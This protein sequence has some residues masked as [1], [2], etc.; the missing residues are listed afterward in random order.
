MN[1][2]LLICGAAALGAAAAWL[3][4]ATRRRTPL[5]KPI[6]LGT[7]LA[8]LVRALSPAQATETVFALLRDQYHCNRV[9]FLAKH[10]RFLQVE[11][12]FGL[13]DSIRQ[14][15]RLQY[16]PS[17]VQACISSFEP[18]DISHIREQAPENVWRSIQSCRLSHCLPV[19]WGD[20]VY[21]IM[22][23]G[24]PESA[25]GEMHKLGAVAQALAAVYHLQWS[26]MSAGKTSG[27]AQTIS[28][29][30]DMARPARQ[31]LKLV[32]HRNPE[33]VVR[34]L[35]SAAQSEIGLE[36]FV[37]MYEPR[38]KGDELQLVAGGVDR[39]V[40]IPGQDHF[41]GL[42][43]LLSSEKA[44]PIF[45]ASAGSGPAADLGKALLEG[46]ISHALLF[47]L[48]DDRRGVFAWGD[49]KPAELITRRLSVFRAAAEDLLEN[50]ESFEKIE[51]LSQTDALTGLYNHRYFH[52]RLT[53]EVNRARR[54]KRSLG[55]VMIDLDQLKAIN[56]VHGHQAGDAIL[57]QVG[58]LLKSSVR[59]IDVIARY[60]GDE[61]CVVMPEAELS[62][63]ESFMARL[64]SEL[65]A[66]KFQSPNTEQIL[67]CT[68]SLGAAVFPDQA[69]DAQKLVFAADMAL[70]RAKEQ[71][72]NTFV[73]FGRQ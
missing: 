31:I 58:A 27:G 16:Q 28:P 46:G 5:Q 53:E 11:A 40:R 49:K 63:C 69:N 64:C 48:T 21:G 39:V 42:V 22:L 35:I 10:R 41:D 37:C 51:E 54:Y 17:M 24:I 20:H 66:T 71:G 61:F 36:R 13:P 32:R 29:L 1:T 56:D 2:V 62:T 57:Q 23:I 14:D 4:I 43:E 7:T 30:D 18:R 8:A 12:Y 9:V 15:I 25:G 34:K 38:Q 26:R 73:V 52:M 3:V 33:T 47:H 67:T 55:L 45:A 60:G 19:F 50:A 59:E 65:A 44:T 6:D 70:L 72:R 68:I